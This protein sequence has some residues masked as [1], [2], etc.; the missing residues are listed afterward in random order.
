MVTPELSEVVMMFVLPVI[1]MLG[2]LCFLSFYGL[3]SKIL[4][5][6]NVENV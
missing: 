4:P 6:R 1:G 3:S 5:I 2:L